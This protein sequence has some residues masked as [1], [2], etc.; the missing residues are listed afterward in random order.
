MITRGTYLALSTGATLALLSSATCL[1]GGGSVS[2]EAIT[3]HIDSELIVSDA[4]DAQRLNVLTDDG[5]VTL[6]GTVNNLLAKRRA[7]D[8]ALATVGV[9]SA[10][11]N[12]VV[13]KSSRSGAEIRA[14]ASAALLADPAT[15]AYEIT[16]EVRQ[17]TATLSGTV[18]SYAEKQ[19]A[20]TV[21]SGV[22]GVMRIE[23]NI[24][25][26]Y[27]SDRPDDEIRADVAQRLAH[28]VTVNDGLLEVAVSDGNV[29]ISGTVGSAAEQREARD[30]AWV[31]GVESVDVS[32]VEIEWWARDNMLRIDLYEQMS[33]ATTRNAVKMAFVHSPLIE[34]G[35]VSVSVDDGVAT[36]TGQVDDLRAKNVAEQLAET[37][38]GV[39]DVEN[40]LRV[41]SPPSLTD[42]QLEASVRG[43]LLRDAYVDRFNIN[44]SVVN[45][46]AH[47]YGTVDTKLERQRAEN[48]TSTI[49]GIVD[50][51]N[52]LIIGD[53]WEA[54]ED[55]KIRESIESEL[56]W[57]PFVDSDDVTVSVVD[58]VARLGG[59]VDT[60]NER[61]AAV[62][63]AMDG[64]AR[65]VDNKLT[66]NYGPEPLAP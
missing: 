66:V 29:S 14:D 13:R 2:D 64:G 30:L 63:N 57:S 8:I 45:G 34:S 60:L 50:V 51:S 20:E 16:V 38:V 35:E 26:D 1:A 27:P 33:D 47:L 24:A 53:E 19:L 12:I 36:L 32:D 65:L 39:W 15:D 25:L 49:D 62:K 18:E 42:D 9:Q 55:W 5:H 31:S 21:V 10:S 41:N 4:V 54:E 56:F 43:A 17:G 22:R 58:G 48:A 11:N 59:T 40:H 7:E 28:T 3:N 46:H 23:N 37:R 6:S 52:Y 61:D 44:V